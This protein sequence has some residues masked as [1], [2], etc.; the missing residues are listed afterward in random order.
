[1]IEIKF[2]GQTHE[3]LT[4]QMQAYLQQPGAAVKPPEP[5]TIPNAQVVS[6]PA[7][8]SAPQTQ[9]MAP[10][11]P[12]AIPA[13]TAVPVPQPPASTGIPTATPTYTRDDLM[14]AGAQ[15]MQK[16]GMPALQQLLGRFGVR[17]I[18]ELPEAQYGAFAQTLREMGGAI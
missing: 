17:A 4:R 2:T 15:L 16:V 7:A 11:Q 1:M 5:E 8:V 6:E 18:H 13:P 12:Q 14:T 3:E 9:P 10:V